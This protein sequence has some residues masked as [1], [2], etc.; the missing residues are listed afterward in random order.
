MPVRDTLLLMVEE[1]G[2]L[3]KEVRKHTGMEIDATAPREVN[4]DL[5][6][7]DVFIYVLALAN[8][9]DIDLAVAYRAKM[10]QVAGRVWQGP[11]GDPT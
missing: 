2:E 3:A 1:V 10:I 4:L 7:A 11:L 8:A 9:L 5:E 6:L